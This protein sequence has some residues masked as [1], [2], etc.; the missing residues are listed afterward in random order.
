MQPD[1]NTQPRNARKARK[2]LKR[3]IC[4]VIPAYRARTTICGVVRGVLPYVD[5]VIVVDDAC[6]DGSG[7]VVTE[8]FHDEV[9][10]QVLRRAQNGGVGAATKTGVA[11]AMELSADIVVKIDAD[12]QMDAAYIPTIARLL[13][14]DQTIAFV[15]GNRFFDPRVIH[16]MPKMR[17]LGNSVLSLLVK[18]ASGYWNL[19]DPTNGFLAFNGRQLSTTDWTRVADDYFFEISVLCELGLQRAPVC[20]LEMETIYAHGGSSLSIP[21]T[22]LSFPPR[23]LGLT[24]RRVL[25]Q[26]V[27]FD[28]NLASMYI[29]L[30]FAS[31]TFGVG[32][33]MFEWI[34]SAL[35]NIPRTTGT[36]MLGVLPFLMG[37]QLLLNALLYDVQFAPRT[38]RELHRRSDL[39]INRFERSSARLKA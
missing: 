27:L 37:F 9:T 18:F 32:F 24:L 36:V 26:Y 14:S 8:T 5:Q 12:D 25:L 1:H 29:L 6:P 22:L 16:K 11:R 35:T 17:L 10:V 30:G 39:A 31:T 33:L 15:K 23:L 3:L 19:L 20:E 4:C 7:D 21:H 13:T 2:A 28:V 38:S 34:Q